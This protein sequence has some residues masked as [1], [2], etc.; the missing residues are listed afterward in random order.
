MAE[1]AKD[2]ADSNGTHGRT[3][4]QNQMKKLAQNHRSKDIKENR[5]PRRAH[6]NI[7]EQVP[8]DPN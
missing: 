8:N 4:A 7:G 6:Q 1:T 3:G 5:I 2:S